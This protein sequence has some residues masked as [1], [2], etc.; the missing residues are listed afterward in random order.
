MPTRRGLLKGGATAA[1][2]GAALFAVEGERT[3]P[4]R[5]A[6]PGGSLDPTTLPKYVTPLPILPA[7]PCANDVDQYA[8][9][10]RQFA[11]QVLPRPF[12]RTTVWGY[13]SVTDPMSF[14]WPAATIEAHA[15]RPVRV[16]W[17]N[18]LTDG[19]GNFRR[20]LLPVDPTVH[21][22]N[23]PGGTGGRDSRPKFTATPGR[24]TGPVPMVVHLHG[25]HS[26]DDSDGYPEAWFLPTARNIPAPFATVGSFYDRFRAEFRNRTGVSWNPGSA[27]FQYGNDQ[28]ATTLWYH[29]H[30][31]GMTRANIYA[32]Q[33]GFYLIRGGRADL[34]AGV[35]PGPAPKVGDP[36]GTRYHEIALV[37]QDRSFDRDGSLF[38]PTTR[39]FFGDVPPEGPFVPNSDVSPIWNPEFFGNT[40]VVNG[41]TWPVMAVE[42]R[43]YRL[44]LLNASN[45]RVL[46]LKIV[47]NPLAARPASP[48]MSFLQ[49]GSDGGFLPAPVGL[50]RLVIAGAERADV[51]VDFSKLPVGTS[52][53]LINEGPDEP[54]GGGEPGTDFDPADPATTGQVMKFVVIPQAGA[55][56]SVPGERLQLPGLTSLGRSGRTR[57]VSLNEM[58][59]ALFPDAPTMGMLGTVNAD[60]TGHE[61]EW[62]DPVTEN[63]ALNAIETWE[64]WNFTEDAHPVHVHLVQFQV[65][66]RQPIGGTLR[67]PQAWEHGFKDT[68]VALP[69]EI[70]R[71]KA[72]F[73]MAG[74][75]VWHCHIID[76]EDNEMMR[77][78]QIT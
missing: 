33:T 9:A 10:V 15:D 19:N 12:P 1:L 29:D 39:G 20:H 5:A 41:A 67:P 44:R 48:A 13:G 58:S 8:I 40:I 43:R 45:T 61:L 50:G 38:F 76:H 57:R 75:Y 36:A 53:Y 77:P 22:A 35:L 71:I 78:I 17:I 31:I 37:I 18:Q 4:A 70:T 73:D 27:T 62:N 55:D 51:I 74:R 54:F 65:A 49:I 7:M 66:N 47:T 34:P 52:L 30:A 11:Q 32:G 64:I 25:A 23:P 69:Q 68:V 72:R 28:R 63:P 21:W 59:S 16:T 60:G 56:T 2:A 46:M 26:N 42:P 3:R 6:V 24:Y 14:G